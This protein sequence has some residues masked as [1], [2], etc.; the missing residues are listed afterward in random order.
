MLF[1]PLNTLTEIAIDNSKKEDRDIKFGSLSGG[2]NSIATIQRI[3]EGKKIDNSKL[4][5]SE[6][7]NM[8]NAVDK[9]PPINI[10]IKHDI[11]AASVRM[12]GF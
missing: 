4:E 11:A 10:H 2:G 6:K 9:R 12:S 1:D 3:M 5:Q 7:E 8:I